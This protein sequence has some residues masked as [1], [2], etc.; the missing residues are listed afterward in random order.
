MPTEYDSEIVETGMEK[1]GDHK[2]NFNIAEEFVKKRLITVGC[3]R[4]SVVFLSID[5]MDKIFTRITYHREAIIAI[6]TVYCP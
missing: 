1:R 3:D 2:A 4:G 6:E 5:N